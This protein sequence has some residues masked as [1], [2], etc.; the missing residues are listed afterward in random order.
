MRNR[1]KPRIWPSLMV[2]LTGVWVCSARESTALSNAPPLPVEYGSQEWKEFSSPEGHFTIL[3]P[4]KPREYVQ[5]PDTKAGRLEKRIYA[6]ETA[7]ATYIVAYDDLAP[8]SA[9]PATI[10]QMLDSGRDQAIA[11]EKGKLLEE[12]NISLDGH[13][14][15]EIVAET[16]EG[17]LKTRVYVVRQRLYQ[18]ILFTPSSQMRSKESGQLDQSMTHKFFES[19]RLTIKP[20][21]KRDEQPLSAQM[22]LLPVRDGDVSGV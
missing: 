19:F 1:L 7:L 11:S 2:I 10:K 6:L 22:R 18:I 15:R 8:F 14:G 9:D 5:P 16:P 3:F 21:E 17:I 13:P 20:E 4:G 12:K